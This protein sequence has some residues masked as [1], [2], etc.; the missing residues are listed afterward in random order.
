MSLRIQIDPHTR[1]RARE[2]GASLE[3]IEDVLRTGP[4]ELAGADRFA[5]YK[6]YDYHGIS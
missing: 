6:I 5:K 2:R 3:Q 1:E 4:S